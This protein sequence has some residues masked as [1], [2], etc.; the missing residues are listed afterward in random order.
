M[1]RNGEQH[2]ALKKYSLT[3]MLQENEKKVSEPVQQEE[4]PVIKEKKQAKKPE[5][6][7]NKAEP[8]VQEVKKPAEEKSKAKKEHEKVMEHSTSIK[9]IPQKKARGTAKSVYFEDDNYAYIDRVSKAND[10]KFSVILNLLIKQF[11][12]EHESE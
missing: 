5:I 9:N 12:E 2:S 6:K 4:K 11:R 1:A 7:E 8:E 3:E 10:V